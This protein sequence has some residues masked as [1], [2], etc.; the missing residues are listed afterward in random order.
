VAL[1]DLSRQAGSNNPRPARSEPDVLG[2]PQT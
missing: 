2:T 1:H